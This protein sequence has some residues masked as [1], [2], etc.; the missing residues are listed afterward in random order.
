MASWIEEIRR[1]GIYNA[2]SFQRAFNWI[3]KASELMERE[4]RESP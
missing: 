1:Q 3:A 4:K 2:A